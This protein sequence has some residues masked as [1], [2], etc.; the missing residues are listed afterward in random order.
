MGRSLPGR[1][2]ESLRLAETRSRGVHTRNRISLPHQWA[3]SD[4]RRTGVRGM[5]WHSLPPAH[6]GCRERPGRPTQPHRRSLQNVAICARRILGVLG[7]GT[8]LYRWR[9]RSDRRLNWRAPT[10]AWAVTARRLQCAGGEQS[11]ARAGYLSPC[12]L[13]MISRGGSAST[14]FIVS[15]DTVTMRAS[16]SKI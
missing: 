3:Q 8:G 14:I 4:S 9:S 7:N 11:E 1:R 13:S 16:R 15:T 5:K 2:A 6:S 10:Q 12:V